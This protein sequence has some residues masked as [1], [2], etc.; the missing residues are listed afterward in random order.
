M[1]VHLLVETVEELRGVVAECRERILLNYLWFGAGNRVGIRVIICLHARGGDA[2]IL[3]RRDASILIV[4]S[5]GD[6]PMAIHGRLIDGL[7]GFWSGE[8]WG[9]YCGGRRG[10]ACHTLK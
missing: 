2:V 6:I 10:L 9:C 8:L 7:S 4:G 1:A 3:I 5:C